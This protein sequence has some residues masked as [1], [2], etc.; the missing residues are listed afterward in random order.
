MKK[1]EIGRGM[2]WRMEG[3]KGSRGETERQPQQ[4]NKLEALENTSPRSNDKT[5]QEIEKVAESLGSF[6]LTRKNLEGLKKKKSNKGTKQKWTGQQGRQP[7]LN[8]NQLKR[9]LELGK[10]RLVDVF[11]SEG[12]PKDIK[13]EGRKM[14]KD[15]MDV[16]SKS[17]EV[18]LENQ[19]R[20]QQ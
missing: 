11:I 3:K 20:L 18:V 19:H 14:R 7:T 17:A 10:R 1:A 8:S 2:R 12:T 5:S 13:R 9:E 15:K 6:D 16:D 4:V